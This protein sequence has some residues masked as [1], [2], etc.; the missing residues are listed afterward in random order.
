MY[1]FLFESGLSF[2]LYFINTLG[3]EKGER[4]TW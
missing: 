4:S 2:L 3:G 1:V